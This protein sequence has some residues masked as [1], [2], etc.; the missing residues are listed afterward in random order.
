MAGTINP[1]EID[2]S[3]VTVCTKVPQLE[4]ETDDENTKR[5]QTI[6]MLCEQYPPEACT[7]VYTDGSATNVIQDNGAGIACIAIYFPSGRT[8]AAS[9]ATWRHYSNY[10]ADSVTVMMDISRDVESQQKSTL[11]V[12][13]TDVLSVLQALT[14]NTLS[15]PTKALQLLRVALQWIL[16]HCRVPGNE[17]ADKLAK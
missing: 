4:Q 1:V 11:V 8:E 3:T 10:K 7:N 6:A 5:T 16:A 17:Q 9:A 12:F 15:H 13:L 14:N 2:I